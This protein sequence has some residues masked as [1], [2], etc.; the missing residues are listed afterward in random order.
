LDSIGELAS[1]YAIA[2]AAFVGGSLVPR[3]G[4]NILEPAQ[5]GKPIFVGP[6]TENFRDIMNIFVQ[7]DAVSVLDPKNLAEEFAGMLDPKWQAMGERGLQ[8][9][10]AHSGATQ[11]TLDAL[12]VLLWIPST[13][14]ARYEQVQR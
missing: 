11:K 13:L 1:L 3:G 8:V 2:T 5:F 12:E 6:F 4:H 10:R 14:K 9:F 7:A